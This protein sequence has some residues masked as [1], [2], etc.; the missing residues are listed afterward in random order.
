MTEPLTPAV[1]DSMI[2][3][4]APYAADG[5]TGDALLLASA[6]RSLLIRAIEVSLGVSTTDAAQWLHKELERRKAPNGR[7]GSP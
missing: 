4:Y 5:V 7:E 6:M 1:I 2:N 3:I